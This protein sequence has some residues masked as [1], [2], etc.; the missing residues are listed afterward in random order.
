M[1]LKALAETKGVFAIINKE[2]TGDQ[3]DNAST[4]VGLGVLGR[5]PMSNLLEAEGRQLLNDGLNT[6][7]RLALKGQHRVIAVEGSE[8]SAVFIELL[9][10]KVDELVGNVEKIGH[11]DGI[12]ARKLK[13]GSVV[14]EV[15]R[16]GE[17]RA[18]L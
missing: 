10:I 5:D 15:K 4:A 14:G 3:E 7:A 16:G 2:V 8:L 17:V 18:Q 1:E 6:L 13:K 12:P 9:I 11:F